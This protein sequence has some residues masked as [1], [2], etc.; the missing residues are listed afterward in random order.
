MLYYKE[1]RTA[2]KKSLIDILA[3]PICK[4]NLVL[5]IQEENDEEVLTGTLNCVEC[6]E[7]YPIED[8]IP[9]L[10]PPNLRS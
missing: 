6:D 7:K 8:S 9:N 3:C 10:L 1:I 5:N 2:V 4:A